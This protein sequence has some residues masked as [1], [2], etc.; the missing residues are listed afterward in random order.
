MIWR[1]MMTFTYF[2]SKLFG[3]HIL[4]RGMQEMSE[5]MLI[6]GK[7]LEGNPNNF[8]ILMNSVLNGIQEPLFKYM[9]MDVKMSFCVLIVMA[10]KNKNII[11][12]I[13]K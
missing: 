3:V 4:K 12:K 1:K 5:S 11:P 9:A 10:G 6:I 8:H 7:I 2:T 13:I